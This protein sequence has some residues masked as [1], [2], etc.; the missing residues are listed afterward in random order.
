MERGQKVCEKGVIWPLS[1]Q[2]PLSSSTFPGI[3]TTVV[4]RELEP[5]DVKERH[6][7]SYLGF[8]LSENLCTTNDEGTT[9]KAAISL[10]LISQ[11]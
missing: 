11:L 6:I 10:N 4:E 9:A 5:N 3:T 8:L 7:V 1:K 2:V